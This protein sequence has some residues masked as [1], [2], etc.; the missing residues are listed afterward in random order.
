M[1]LIRNFASVLFRLAIITMGVER[2]FPGWATREFFQSF[3]RGGPKVV[4]F[5]FPTR[6]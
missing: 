6:N 5:V 4:K 2:F 3:S 1:R